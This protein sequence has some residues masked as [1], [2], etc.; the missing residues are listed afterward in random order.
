MGRRL[1]RLSCRRIG[2]GGRRCVLSRSGSERSSSKRR[3]KP[4]R[5]HRV[6]KVQIQN[7]MTDSSIDSWGVNLGF[8]GFELGKS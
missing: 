8:E 6:G 4:S 2:R 3:L 5:R 7:E 1:V